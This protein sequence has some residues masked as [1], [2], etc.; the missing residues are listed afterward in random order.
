MPRCPICHADFPNLTA[1]LVADHPQAAD[2]SAPVLYPRAAPSNEFVSGGSQDDQTYCFQ[3]SRQ[4]NTPAALAAHLRDAPVHTRAE[5]PSRLDL[6]SPRHQSR[7][8]VGSSSLGDRSE[9]RFR[10]LETSASSRHGSE[11]DYLAGSNTSPV[12]PVSGS[13]PPNQSRS[14]SGYS[15]VRGN[16]DRPVGYI[17]EEGLIDSLYAQTSSDYEYS[18]DESGTDSGEASDV[19]MDVS[20]D[21]PSTERHRDPC[22]PASNH[23]RGRE[24]TRDHYNTTG[25]TS[26][27]DSYTYNSN[28]PAQHIPIQPNSLS[29]GVNAYTS[30][31][32]LDQASN[33]QVLQCRTC[34]ITHRRGS[35]LCQDTAMSKPQQHSN[36][37]SPNPQTSNTTYGIMCPICL[38]QTK[39]ATSTLCGHIFCADCIN[40][41]LAINAV[42]PVCKRTNGQYSVHPIYP[43][44]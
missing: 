5:Y 21:E 17:T 37:T 29:A 6:S 38:E 30:D 3:C 20:G 2:M 28:T 26:S 40:Q 4:F 10:S 31:S 19:S 36:P 44:F 15:S 9:G 7:S 8:S 23:R 39:A 16:S 27:Q 12:P 14:T 32:S 42:C 33:A 22:T 11:S 25:A 24:P 18:I 43:V 1:H 35:S 41:A 34:G 13:D